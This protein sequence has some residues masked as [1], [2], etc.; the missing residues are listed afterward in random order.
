M[1]AAQVGEATRPLTMA[2][3]EEFCRDF[4]LEPEFS[5]H[6][7]IRGLSGGQKVRGATRSA[8]PLPVTTSLAGAPLFSPLTLS[9]WAPPFST[10]PDLPRSSWCW[11]RP[12]G[13]T[14]TCL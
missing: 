1:R 14:R 9:S 4:G 13:R 10:L 3:I 7:N 12:C 8:V 2:S 6:S 11:R 5:M